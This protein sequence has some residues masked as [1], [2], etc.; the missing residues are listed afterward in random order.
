MFVMLFEM[1]EKKYSDCKEDDIV[2][3]V[4]MWSLFE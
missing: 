4:T 2:L 3:D 1:S